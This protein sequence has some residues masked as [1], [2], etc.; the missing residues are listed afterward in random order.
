M[1]RRQ[2]A[3]AGL[4]QHHQGDDAK[5]DRTGK[6]AQ[7]AHLAAAE[8]EGLIVGMAAGIAV[9]VQGDHEGRHVRAHVPAVGEQGHGAEY[10]AGGDF[11]NHGQE[12]QYQN[13]ARSA[14]AFFIE[15]GVIVV[16]L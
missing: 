1:A 15:Y 4:Y 11:Q 16:V 12:S 2:N 13:Q 10:N 7:N 3:L 8:S 5:R 9:G 14:L 6:P